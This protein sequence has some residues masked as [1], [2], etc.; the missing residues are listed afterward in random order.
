MEVLN[1]R[2]RGGDSVYED[3]LR[4]C[5]KHASYISKPSQNELINCCGNYIKGIFVKEIVRYMMELLL[6]LA[7][8]MVYLA[9]FFV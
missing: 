5:S 6:F 7:I 1:Y 2:I 9:K 8:S 3:H 4:T